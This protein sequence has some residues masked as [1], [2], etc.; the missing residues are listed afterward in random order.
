[1]VHH[2]SFEFDVFG[3][4]ITQPKQLDVVPRLEYAESTAPAESFTTNR[5]PQSP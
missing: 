2:L 1:M 5:V 4:A 3:I